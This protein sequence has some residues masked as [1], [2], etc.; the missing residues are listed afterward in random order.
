[1]VDGDDSR[2]VIEGFELQA[3]AGRGAMGVVYRALRL[4]SG[5]VVALKI[6]NTAS[7][8]ERIRWRRE[9][10][11]LEA[12][13]SD[14]VVRLLAHGEL[15][16]DRLWLAMT[17]ISGET[18]ASRLRRG[19]LEEREARALLPRLADGLAAIHRAG[20]VHRD[21]KP[22]NILLP[23][24]RFDR[25]MIADFG[26]ARN[27]GDPRAT[28]TGAQIGT[29]AYMAPEQAR[30]E[31][32]LTKAADVFS[33]AAVYYE[34]IAGV[35]PFPG[36]TAVAV[37][38]RILTDVAE[39]VR[40]RARWVPA[41]LDRL[42]AQML[43]RPHAERPVDGAAVA[44]A[45]E[46]ALAG[47]VADEGEPPVVSHWERRPVTVLLARSVRGTAAN[48]ATQSVGK[49]ASGVAERFGEA[50]EQFGGRVEVLADGTLFVVF[51]RA[52][53]A[54]DQA[55]FAGRAA[56]A[57]RTI[58]PDLRVVLASGRVLA[59]AGGDEE[60]SGDAAEHALTLLGSTTSG[61]IRLDEV[62]ANLLGQGF[63]LATTGDGEELVA[64]RP[65]VEIGQP[66]RGR[67]VPCVGRELELATLDLVIASAAAERVPRAVLVL[68]PAGA[69]K[70][71]LRHELVRRL[72]NQ[73]HRVVAGRSDPQAM[74]VP[75]ALLADIAPTIRELLREEHAVERAA[76]RNPFALRHRIVQETVAWLRDGSATA[77]LVVVLDDLHWSDGPS[78]EVLDEAFAVLKDAPVVLA[79]FARPEVK[80][81]HARAL[82]R[83]AQQEIRL[84][85]LSARAAEYLL[86]T[87]LGAEAIPSEVLEQLV[88]VA[89]GNALFL[90]ELARAVPTDAST[91]WFTNAPRTV[92]TLLEERCAAR[93]PA[94][95]RLL[96]AASV[97]G[98]TFASDAVRSLLQGGDDGGAIDGTLHALVGAELIASSDDGR[99]RFRH[100]LVREA[101][102]ALLPEE[103]RVAAHGR[104]F[105]IG[106]ASG[107]TSA[108]EL[109]EH[110]RQ[111][112]L[113]EETVRWSF[114]AAEESF[115]AN[116]M[117]TS[118]G[119][120]RRVLEV[121]PSPEAR[122]T[123]LALGS[124]ASFFSGDLPQAH[125]WGVEAMR[126]APRKSRWWLRCAGNMSAI[127]THVEPSRR[128]KSILD[129]GYRALIEL[130]PDPDEWE[131]LCESL[132]ITL[133]C[134]AGFDAE[135]TDRLADRLLDLVARA[136]ATAH[137]A[138]GWAHHGLAWAA[139]FVGR[140]GDTGVAHAEA[141]V[142]AFALASDPRNRLASYAVL[143]MALVT[144]DAEAALAASASAITI[145]LAEGGGFPLVYARLL[146][147]LVIAR[148]AVDRVGC[149]TPALLTEAREHA[150]FALEVLGMSAFMRGYSETILGSIALVEG[151][152]EQAARHSERACAALSDLVS[153]ADHA[154]AVLLMAAAD[155]HAID[156]RPARIAR[157]RARIARI[158]E[159]A[160]SRPLLERA[161]SA[162][163]A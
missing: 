161:L 101:A 102:Y 129:E 123:T 113:T 128:T 139:V 53:G 76:M 35:P 99:Y 37:L 41:A 34:A 132:A 56:L 62:T 148:L 49:E 143:A 69:G 145:G 2:P 46:G 98:V 11:A 4:D 47:E 159:S 154:L 137:S 84:P 71:R 9:V 79:A 105:A 93:P 66:V 73:A 90:E 135:L 109:A 160:T 107:E 117:A 155:G 39:P 6:L 120:V 58:E 25:A 10:S 45:L 140:H 89:D 162:P 86:R 55:M 141:A 149:V 67:L 119:F 106:I 130:E 60:V 63:V 40:V 14:A 30:G 44:L 21:L 26:L 97:L 61:V 92:L 126:L 134:E 156:D 27:E 20:I 15:S 31:R 36:A 94:E 5:D 111:A 136:P 116:D 1:M 42:L 22:A 12:L 59:P 32:G 157:A 64:E 16:D 82:Q 13:T 87:A 151:D 131:S 54:R 72:G 74:E 163:S 150:R 18:L 77:P 28:A 95:R 133:N 19:R 85:K 124:I 122:G 57:L 91:A 96:R 23:D 68:A 33:L 114:R 8:R 17:W 78:V 29:P 38:A 7:E 80:E 146:R 104:A 118:L 65:D 43:R 115:A 110:A 70:S 52:T 142:A 100:P 127:L 112:R 50:C 81:R 144:R 152:G 125:A 158:G 138:R 108:A 75:F 83:L 3:L 121:D 51:S 48:D 153:L 88:T 24:G 147:G 103:D